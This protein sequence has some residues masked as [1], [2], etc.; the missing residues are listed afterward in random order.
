MRRSRL[1]RS[2][3]LTQGLHVSWHEE[4]LREMLKLGGCV[5][6]YIQVEVGAHLAKSERAIA[7]C[8]HNPPVGRGPVQT[9]AQGTRDVSKLHA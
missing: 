1:L 9:I 8:L 6:V 3:M 7:T 4:P 5:E 2:V